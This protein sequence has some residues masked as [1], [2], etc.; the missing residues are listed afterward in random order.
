MD[1]PEIRLVLL[2]KT[3]SGK[4]ATGNTIVN[5]KAFKTGFGGSSVTKKCQSHT[6]NRFGREVLV[7]DTPGVFDTDTPNDSIMTELNKCILL[8]APGP[9]AIILVINV[10]NRITGEENEN[11]EKFVNRFGENIYRY[12]IVLFT[13]KDDLIDDEK[14]EEEYLREVPGN[15]QK[16]LNRCRNRCIF[17]NNK[18]TVQQKNQQVRCL[19]DMIDE[20]VLANR[21]TFFQ[22]ENYMM[23]EKVIKRMIQKRKTT[24]YYKDAT[25]AY[26]RKTI[27]KDVEKE[28]SETVETLLKFAAAV[29]AISPLDASMLK[30]K[31]S[32]YEMDQ[33]EIR[34]VLLGKTG[35]GKSATGNTIVNEKVFRTGLG[36]SSVT[37]KCQSHTANRFGRDVLV[38]DTPGAFDTDVHT[39]HGDKSFMKELSK[40]ILISA[41]GPHA[42]I[43]VI[44]VRSRFTIE[45]HETVEKFVSRFGEKIYR[46]FIVLFTG[47]DELSRNE[48]SE[49]EY[50]SEVPKNLKEILKRCGYRCIFFNNTAT[51]Q[52]GNQ[53]VRCLLDMIDKN[54][55][56]NRGSFFEDKILYK[57]GEKV[58]SR[59]IQKRKTKCND[60]DVT[61]AYLRKTIRKDLENEDPETTQSLF[62]IAASIGAII[63]FGAWVLKLFK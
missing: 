26:L 28:D 10:R 63:L 46:Y 20:N 34:L 3:G 43:L 21:G 7:V 35:S 24:Y 2:G 50:L 54:V 59:M 41:P 60:K 15:V 44:N 56:A 36:G 39:L 17:F 5:E 31:V 1:R 48:T 23:G 58:M 53:Q 22:D 30:L 45:E 4:S 37:K 6:A 18:A 33:P 27:R 57:E 40:C 12:F 49:E 61:E 8:S 38:V 51:L 19:L 52:E 42:I 13:G 14:S 62:S 55:A 16:I 25:E 29:G 32:C 11:V 9:H 47:K